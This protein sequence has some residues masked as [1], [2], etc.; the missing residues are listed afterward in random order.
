MKERSWL[1][2][3]T[4]P[5][6]GWG[7]VWT[8]FGSLQAMLKEGATIWCLAALMGCGSSLLFQRIANPQGAPLSW[9]HAVP[10]EMDA[11]RA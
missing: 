5:F 7:A 1:G 3:C 2:A 9:D 4:I 6:P 10:Q 8:S 11:R